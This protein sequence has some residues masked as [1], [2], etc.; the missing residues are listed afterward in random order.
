MRLLHAGL[1][2][3]RHR[4]DRATKARAG[5]ARTGGGDGGRGAGEAYLPLHRIRA[6]LPSGARLDPRDIRS[7]AGR[8]MTVRRT[9]LRVVIIAAVVLIVG[10]AVAALAMRHLWFG[11]AGGPVQAV[12]APADVVARGKYLAEAAD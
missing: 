4:A 9:G 6:L 12:N 5:A 1:R 10:I 11:K 2:Q 7:N 8:R 3:R